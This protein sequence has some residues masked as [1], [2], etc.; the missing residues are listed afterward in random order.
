[1]GPQLPTIGIG[2]QV[3]RAVEMLEMAPPCSSCREAVRW[4]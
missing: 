3:D 2:Q 1:M 4:P